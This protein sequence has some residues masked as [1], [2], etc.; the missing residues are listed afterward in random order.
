MRR[1]A[2]LLSCSMM[3]FATAALAQSPASPTDVPRA[4][5]GPGS[6]AP[7]VRQYER[8]RAQDTARAAIR[9]KAEFETAQRDHRLA[10]MKWFGYSNLRPTVSTDPYSTYSPMWVG[11]N[12][13]D[14]GQWRGTQ[15]VP[16]YNPQHVEVRY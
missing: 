13:H 3:L 5:T 10:A 7:E 6:A 8:L 1:N 11:N 16:Q 14:P 9:E 15:T 2:I 4:T 12:L